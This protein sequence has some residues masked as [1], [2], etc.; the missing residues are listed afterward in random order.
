VT[1]DE[2]K[3]AGA[4]AF[5]ANLGRAPAL[6]QRFTAEA[7]TAAR[8]TGGGLVELLGAYGTGWTVAHLAADAPL[9]DMPSVIEFNRLMAA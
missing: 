8:E 5:I 9:P 3:K 2:A 7:C 1:I 4:E 6:N